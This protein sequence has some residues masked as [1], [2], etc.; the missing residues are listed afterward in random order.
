MQTILALA[1]AIAAC[2]KEKLIRVGDTDVWRVSNKTLVFSSGLS[3][4]AD[5]APNAYH[6]NDTGIDHLANA[7]KPGNWWALVTED[8]KPSGAP[9]L[10][11]ASDPFPG[12]Y[13]SMTSLEDKSKDVRDPARYVDSTKV[14]YI[15]ISPLLLTRKLEGGA[16]VGDFVAVINIANNKI[17]YAIIADVGPKDHLG[18]GSIALAETLGIASSPKR[19]GVGKNIVYAVFPSSG[20]GKPRTLEE[21]R[22]RGAD[23]LNE[24]GGPETL[25][26]CAK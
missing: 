20:T 2:P 17:A 3:V 16:K 15:A 19:G 7:G 25:K 5:G 21:I 26:S 24:L 10:Q 13:V 18:E 6:P 4:D 22:A 9:I 8:G 1:L 23:L 11:K 12:Y 14:P